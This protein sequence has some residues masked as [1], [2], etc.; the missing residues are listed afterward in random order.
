M[1]TT[2]ISAE[3][4][5][6]A[7]I[8]KIEQGHIKEAEEAGS[9]FIRQ[10]LY[11]DGFT[12][13]ILVPQTKTAEDL[14]PEVDSD[15]PRILV[16]K[17]PDAPAATFV[18]FKGTGDRMYFEGN[19]FAIP[20]GK[21]ETERQAKSKFELMTIR[22]PIMD[23]F[24][25]NHV[26]QIQ[27]VEDGNFIETIRAN[28]A[29][30][31]STRS[32]SSAGGDSFKTAFTLG[33]KGLTSLRVPIGCVLMHENTRLSSLALKTDEIGYKAQDSRFEKGLVDEAS[34]MGYPVV[35]TIDTNKVAENEMFF[36]APADYLGKFYLLQDA[37]L[38][39]KTEADM[40]TFHTYEAPGI[41][42]GNVNSCFKVTIG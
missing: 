35:T 12:R 13:R 6:S 37:T 36:F 10:K 18:P 31:T 39:I 2:Q 28:I 11:E 26:K 30:S 40:Y 22:M 4:I 38:Y 33:L 32:T 1:E 3:V 29:L 21:I 19:R 5:N 23:W 14:D 8:D 24:K 15:K 17:E 42:I 34:F 27:A 41:G 25:Q 20:F 9:N 16:E 7:F